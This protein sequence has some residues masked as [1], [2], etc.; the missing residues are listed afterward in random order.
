MKVNVI[1]KKSASKGE[2]LSWATL[3]SAKSEHTKP[4][5]N[6]KG[7]MFASSDFPQKQTKQSVGKI[8]VP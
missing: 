8:L 3:K 4:G 6:I 2:S 7:K 5:T 1:H